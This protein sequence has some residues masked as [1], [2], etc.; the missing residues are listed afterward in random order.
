MKACVDCHKSHH[1]PIACNTCH[2][3]GQ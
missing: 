2:E 3:L 1:A